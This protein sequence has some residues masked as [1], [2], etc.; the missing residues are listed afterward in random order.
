M[1]ITV[2][3]YKEYVNPD[4]IELEL[5][6]G[7]KIKFEKKKIAGGS[8]AYQQLLVALDNMDRNPNAKKA[9]DALANKAHNNLMGI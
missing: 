2:K 4:Y 3:A 9:I 1:N 8:K 6:N 7:K 5:S